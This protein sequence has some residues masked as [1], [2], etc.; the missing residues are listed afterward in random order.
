MRHR[1]ALALCLAV[2]LS[3][4]Q[5]NVAAWGG[6]FVGEAQVP[7]GL[8]GVVQL[9]AGSNHAV[10][11]T[12][13]GTVVCWGE[14]NSGQSTVPLGL[15]GVV[16][17]DAG[18]DNTIALKSN[19]TCVIWGENDFGQLNK[20]ADATSLVQVAVGSS[21]VLGVRANGAVVAWGAPG[22][23]SVPAGLANVKAVSAGIGFNLALTEDGVVVAWGANSAGQTDVPVAAQS[24]VVAISAG[25][26]HAIA[27]KANGTVVCWGND[28]LDQSSPPA[29]LTG[30]KAVAA[31]V[32]HSMALLTNGSIVAWGSNQHNSLL[33]PAGLSRVSQIAAGSSTGYA[34]LEEGPPSFVEAPIVSGDS[35]R[36]R[37][38]LNAAKNNLGEVVLQ[39]DVPSALGPLPTIEV[40]NT[41]TKEFI[42]T[43][44]DVS[45]DT[46]VRVRLMIDRVAGSGP[47]VSRT[48]NPIAELRLLVK[49]ASLARLDALDESVPGG[50]AA[51]CRVSLNGTA[52]GAGSSVSLSS[53]DPGLLTVPGTTV[54]PAGSRSVTF[55]AAAVA[56]DSTDVG[57]VRAEFDG[58]S[59]TATVTVT[60]ALPKQIDLPAN[61]I[62]SGNV[63]NGV[64]LKLRGVAGP[65]GVQVTLGVSDPSTASVPESLTVNPGNS[66][67]S[68]KVTTTAVASP[69]TVVIF[70][71]ANGT[72]VTANLTVNP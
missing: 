67:V 40:V 21:N 2:P 68:F 5:T 38:R 11:L 31:G 25:G 29:G 35:Q 62:I 45:A 30:V 59:R 4:A 28:A 9:A 34:I 43:A 1:F 18:P 41:F 65:S 51:S 46:P 13:A 20:P 23:A 12:S 14:N 39:S 66:Q 42:L 3:Q 27:L 24:G 47:T 10:A 8:S 32:F 36:F 48:Q 15:T 16:Q 64:L 17:V 57:T 60:P 56:V 37:V 26:A 50:T 69:K 49:K 71:T 52:G 54:V 7:P 55:P 63:M 72:T 58:L 44:S 6:D 61:S 22:Q 70:A 33:L 19:G 53:L